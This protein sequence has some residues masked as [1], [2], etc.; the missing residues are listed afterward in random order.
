MRS[1]GW[2][3][4][5]IPRI[6]LLSR[7]LPTTDS[8]LDSGGKL[9]TEALL[10]ALAKVGSVTAFGYTDGPVSGE[11]PHARR[12]QVAPF[13]G[14]L[15]PLTVAQ[16]FR[17][18]RT[19]S[20]ATSGTYAPIRAF[21]RFVNATNPDVV[22]VEYGHFAGIVRALPSSQTLLFSSQNLEYRLFQRRSIRAR[23][24]RRAVMRAD[25][26]LVKRV[27]LAAYNKFSISVFTT[28]RDRDEMLNEVG[29]RSS[30]AILVC[31]N[32]FDL[33]SV[34][35]SPKTLTRSGLEVLFVGSLNWGPNK[36]GIDRFVTVIW[37]RIREMVPLARLTIAGRGPS[38][39]DVQRWESVPSIQVIPNPETLAPLY[40]RSTVSIVPLDAGGGSRIKIL[41]SLAN[42]VPVVASTI[43]AE[44]LEN[45]AGNGLY[46]ASSDPEFISRLTEVLS[47]PGTAAADGVR[48]SRVISERHSWDAAFAPLRAE[49]ERRL[50]LNT[51]PN[52]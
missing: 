11:I 17:L 5:D 23:G 32:G 6:A 31:P 37:P 3:D 2:S 44:G 24:C 22:V 1:V 46:I 35:Q 15:T 18:L 51:R 19:I 33:L 25:S 8:P 45:L 49:I 40:A 47:D 36:Q 29:I 20:G 10:R 30:A 4:G 48:G 7:M 52:L 26:F 12:G 42:G 21:I 39:R 41:E 34:D 38:Q 13:R 9:R 43:G 14:G 50:R 27:E 28:L 16:N